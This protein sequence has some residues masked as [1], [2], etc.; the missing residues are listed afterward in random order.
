LV[1]SKLTIHA[2]CTLRL[3]KGPKQKDQAC[4]FSDNISFS[5]NDPLRLSMGL[6]WSNFATHGM[7]RCMTARE[8]RL[9]V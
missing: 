2:Y 7:K 3:E 8:T 6:K 1:H 4:R 9:Q 5:P